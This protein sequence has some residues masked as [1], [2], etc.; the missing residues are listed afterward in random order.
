[1]EALNQRF[2]ALED[3]L[4]DIYEQGSD[5]L[6]DQIKHWNF[7][8][9]EQILLHYARRRGI[10]RLGYTPVPSLA[11]SETKAKDAIYMVLQL[12]K[13]RDSPYKDEPWTLINTSLETYRAPPV[14]CFKKGPQNVEV[15]FDADPENIMLYTS[16]QFI[17]FEDTDGHWQKTEGRIDYAGLY[18]LE[19]QLRHYYVEFK[20]DARRFGTSGEWEVRFNGETIFA[21]VTSSSPSSFEEVRERAEPPDVPEVGTAPDSGTLQTGRPGTET[22]KGRR[23]GRKESSPTVASLRVRQKVSRSTT[24]KA[25]ERRSRSPSS[26]TEQA[27]ARGRGQRG[28]R[29]RS[30]TRSRSKRRSRSRSSSRARSRRAREHSESRGGRGRGAYATRSRSRSAECRSIDQ[31]G[32]PASQVGRSVQS[33]GRNNSSRLKRLLD[34]AL[35][36]PVILLRGEPNTLKCYR[37]R[38][39]D[40]LRGSFDK[41]STTWSWV[42]SQG[43]TRI[44]RARMLLSFISEDQREKFINVMK[45]PKGVDWSFGSFDSL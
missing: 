41:I 1:M 5:K 42:A 35:D 29:A 10:M 11:A 25:E 32:I 20:V 31:C 15:I 4:M 3:Q 38:V 22:A 7:L 26:G 40:K 45:L 14:N 23:Y 43:N 36:P 28:T 6:E 18:Y 34:E 21:P 16:W 27:G 24:R 2:N 19:G 17:Y 37:Y 12:E 13:L 8:R 30:R 9:K 33:V 39:K 44:G